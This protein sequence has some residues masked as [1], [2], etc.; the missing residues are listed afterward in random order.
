[1]RR[2]RPPWWSQVLFIAWMCWLY[3]DINNF[4]PLRVGFAYRN[5][6]RFLDFERWLHLDPEASLDHWLARHSVLSWIAGNYYD[7]FHFIVTLGLIG[8]VWWKFPDRYRPLRNGLILTNLIAM[9][10][11]WL[12]PTAPPRL[13]DPNVYVDVV[14]QSHAFGSWH[15]GALANAAN[16]LAAMPSLHIGWAMWS[17][18]VVWR[19]AAGWRWRWLV[20]VYPALTAVVVM[21]TGNHYLVDVLAGAVVFAL[22]QIIADRWDGW[23]TSREARR[24]L[25]VEERAPAGQL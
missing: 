8:F 23:W 16:E 15:T 19:I 9:A 20:W 21:A 6:Q 12:V 3:D 1:M 5:G 14:A 17:S 13:L 11:F 25:E 4:S 2:D 10:V 24:A 22:S 18:F 7:N